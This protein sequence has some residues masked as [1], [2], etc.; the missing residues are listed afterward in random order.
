MQHIGRM[1][2]LESSEHLV[3]EVTHLQSEECVWVW[4][5]EGACPT[6]SLL[7][8]CVFKSL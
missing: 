1:D 5:C 2:V 3:E 8:L 6:W 7:N 4:V